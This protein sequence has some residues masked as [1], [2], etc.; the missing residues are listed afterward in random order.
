MKLSKQLASLIAVMAIALLLNG[1]LA[2]K[3]LNNQLIEGRKHEIETILN[4][5]LNQV[6]R[7]VEME[8][9]G[10]ITREQA[11]ER[12]VDILSGIRYGSSYIWANDNNGI[13]RVHVRDGVVGTYQKSYPEAIAQLRGK[14]LDFKVSNNSKPGTDEMI[15]K[16]NG[17]AKIPNWNWVMGIGAYMDDIN[18]AYWQVVISFLALSVLVLAVII[19]IALYIARN[20]LGK[21]GGEPSYAM[22]IT[23]HIAQGNLDE[24]I[25]GKFSDNSLLGSISKMQQSLRDAVQSIRSGSK[26]LT[27]STAQLK[28]QME[29]IS[30]ASTASSDASHSTA[31]SIQELSTCIEE[32]AR[33][34]TQTEDNS[35][36]S[37]TMCS[38][39]ETVVLASSDHIQAISKQLEESVGNI[40]KL[41]QRSSQI[42]EVVNVIN[43]IAEQTNLLALNA[44]IEAAR[45][46]EQGRGFAVVADEVRT[47]ASRTAKATSEITD[48]IGVVQTET[49]QVANLVK[50]ILPTVENSVTTSAQ[51]ATMLEDI[52][53]SSLDTLTMVKDVSNATSEQTIVAD[54]LAKHFEKISQ[55]INESNNAVMACN[56][57]VD[58]LDT[59]A[60]D[61]DDAIRIFKV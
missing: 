43:D 30:A 9:S 29:N 5:T 41:Q 45:A 42:G 2:L 19:A 48:T 59:L 51:V 32:I 25:Q 35:V 13:A 8:Q 18:E 54:E 37:N 31:A 26:Q 49:D 55:M 20:I 44:A 50:S 3:L 36:R 39:G 61:L 47:L 23:Q 6:N 7:W 34:A 28:T 11:E 53:N 4:L 10:Q 21:I 14:T 38:E 52:K 60:R 46:G 57:N 24:K 15:V 12:V 1:T 56:T 16:I 27:T 33:H 40:D 17:M 22:A 58:D